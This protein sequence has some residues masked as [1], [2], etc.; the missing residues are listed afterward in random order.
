MARIPKEEA[1]EVAEEIIMEA[2]EDLVIIQGIEI[3]TTIAHLIT[4]LEEEAV[5]T[6]PDSEGASEVGHRISEAEIII[7][8]IIKDLA[9]KNRTEKEGDLRLDSED[10]V[11][12]ASE[13]VKEGLITRMMTRAIKIANLVKD[14]F[15][16]LLLNHLEA[17]DED[18]E[19]TDLNLI[20]LN[21]QV[22]KIM[23]K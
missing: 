11:E 18:L 13:V 12:E 10:E 2:E 7:T 19:G 4:A 3:S 23:L 20:Q 15:L 9:M 22:L 5:D 14:N 21:L 6:D 8:I 17:E 1:L 16:M